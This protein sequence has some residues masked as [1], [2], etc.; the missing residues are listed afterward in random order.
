MP[1]NKLHGHGHNKVEIKTSYSVKLRNYIPTY[2]TTSSLVL[3]KTEMLMKSSASSPIIKALVQNAFDILV[4]LTF[5]FNKLMACDKLFSGSLLE[6]SNIW[7]SCLSKSSQ[8]RSMVTDALLAK[9]NAFGFVV[10]TLNEDTPWRTTQIRAT[11]VATVSIRLYFLFFYVEENFFCDGLVVDRIFDT[12][13][14]ASS[15]DGFSQ[16]H[17]DVK[18][19]EFSQLVGTETDFCAD[20][21]IIYLH[22]IHFS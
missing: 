7:A 11:S 20:I 22:F 6:P 10:I 9:R 18:F 21:Q 14:L 13:S 19:L 12:I 2:P 15:L 4:I 5:S 16:S 1:Y 17:G 8:N 3:T